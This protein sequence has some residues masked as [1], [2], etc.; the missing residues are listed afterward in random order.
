MATKN[1]QLR[2]QLLLWDVMSREEKAAVGEPDTLSGWARAH[3]IS[4]RTLNYWRAEEE[5]L[6]EKERLLAQRAAR[7]AAGLDQ[8]I[9]RVRGVSQV[10]PDGPV[11]TVLPDVDPNTTNTDLFA[12]IVRK[13]LILAQSGDKGAL[14]FI[15]SPAVSKPLLDALN[16]E[17]E[18]SDF[19]DASDEELVDMILDSFPELVVERARARGLV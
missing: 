10:T 15:K 7:A 4:P 14:D 13:Q 9:V 18:A 16:S 12:D 11:P 6:S 8:G 19:P 1:E 17:T 3:G 2:K 5:Y